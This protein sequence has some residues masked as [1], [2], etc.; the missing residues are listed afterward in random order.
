MRVKTDLPY[1][2]KLVDIMD[3]S[4]GL[5]HFDDRRADLHVRLAV[6]GSAQGRLLWLDPADKICARKGRWRIWLPSKT[7]IWLFSTTFGYFWLF[8]LGLHE[9]W[10]HFQKSPCQCCQ[11]WSIHPGSWRA[12]HWQ[13]IS[14]QAD[15]RHRQGAH[16]STVSLKAKRSE[17]AKRI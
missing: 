2:F 12:P 14:N 3:S 11:T 6:P 16:S 15:L 4:E 13:R 8:L 1:L 17:L 7:V 10:H 9:Y 5:A